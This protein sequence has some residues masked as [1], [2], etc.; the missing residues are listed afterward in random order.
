MGMLDLRVHNTC[1]P[2]T[3]E[4]MLYPLLAF[5]DDFFVV[6]SIFCLINF[7]LHSISSKLCRF[8]GV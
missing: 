4:M 1:H 7:A 6:I 5:G 2:N 3:I 8:L